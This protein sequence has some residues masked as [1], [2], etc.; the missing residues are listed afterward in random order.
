MSQVRSFVSSSSTL[1]DGFELMGEPVEQVVQQ[2]QE[3]D[4]EEA[5]LQ[6]QLA[7]SGT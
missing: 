6:A 7:A 5:D 3:P 1:A 2:N 4:A